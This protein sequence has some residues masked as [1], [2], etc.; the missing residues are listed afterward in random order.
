MKTRTETVIDVMEWDAEVQRIYGRPYALQQ[1]DGGRPRG[2]LR[3]SVPDEAE[4]D[5]YENDTVPEIVNGD[6]MGVSFKAWCNRDPNDHTFKNE[7][8]TI[9]WWHRNFYPDFQTLANDLHD[10]GV[11]QAGEYT[12]DILGT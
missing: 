4:A 2:T 12:I 7:F 10:K 5:D 9:L 1:Q 3:F 8:S 11:L 6:E